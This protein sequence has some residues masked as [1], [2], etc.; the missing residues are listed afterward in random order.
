MKSRQKKGVF[1]AIQAAAGQHR[2]LTV[3]TLL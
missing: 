1:A 2:L 3:G